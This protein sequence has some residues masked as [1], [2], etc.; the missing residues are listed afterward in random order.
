MDCPALQRV[1]VS[2]LGLLQHYWYDARGQYAI[3]AEAENKLMMLHAELLEA[4]RQL[5]W[6]QNKSR[7]LERKLKV[8]NA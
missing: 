8:L 1:N 7:K 4:K 2:G 6:Y 3:A 5:S